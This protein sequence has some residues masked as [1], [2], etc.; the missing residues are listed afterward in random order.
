MPER[1]EDPRLAAA[2]EVNLAGLR[3]TLLVRAGRAPEA[4]DLLLEVQALARR[5][6][7][8]R[9]MAPI[10]TNFALVA[11]SEA[12][13]ELAETHLR[14]ALGVYEQHGSL[15]GIAQ[16]QASLGNLMRESGRLAEGQDWLERSLSARRLLGQQ[17]GVMLVRGGLALLLAERGHVAAALNELKA[18]G[19]ALEEGGPGW[20][21]AP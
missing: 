11:R 18:V 9:A 2:L 15:S 6:G 5:A 20:R 17:D 8:A 14:T 10:E 13:F 12:Q 21:S 16:V 19:V 1:P 7:E 3:S 4:R